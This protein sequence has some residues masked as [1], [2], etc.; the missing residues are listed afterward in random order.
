MNIKYEEYKKAATEYTKFL[1]KE[2]KKMYGDKYKSPM[3]LPSKDKKEFFNHIEKNWKSKE[4]S[5][6][7]HVMHLE[8]LD[9]SNINNYFKHYIS[10][11]DVKDID[12]RYHLDRFDISMWVHGKNHMYSIEASYPLF[13]KGQVQVETFSDSKGKGKKKIDTSV[14]NNFEDA[15]KVIKKREEEK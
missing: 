2:L 10:D 8:K 7:S 5:K 15:I 13:D 9:K 6:K 3:Q 11:F 4:E 1:M 12:V 14:Y